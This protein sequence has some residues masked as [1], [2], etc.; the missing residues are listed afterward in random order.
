MS[1][2]NNV[3]INQDMCINCHGGNGSTMNKDLAHESVVAQPL[4]EITQI[5]IAATPGLYWAGRNICLYPGC[6]TWNLR[7][8]H[9]CSCQQILRRTAIWRY[10]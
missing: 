9:A 7:N 3:H 5:V 1:E 10:L 6:Y 8:A 2:W 4:S